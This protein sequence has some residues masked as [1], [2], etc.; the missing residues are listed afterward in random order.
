[1]TGGSLPWEAAQT[2]TALGQVPSFTGQAKVRCKIDGGA[3]RTCT[4]LS[5]SLALDLRTSPGLTLLVVFPPVAPS[6]PRPVKWALFQVGKSGQLGLAGRESVSEGEEWGI[7]ECLSETSVAGR[8][9]S[10]HAGGGG[11][12][13]HWTQLRLPGP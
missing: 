5:T 3:L 13:P 6:S 12:G 4:T 1:M 2:T 8:G 9:G 11:S 10:E 7:G